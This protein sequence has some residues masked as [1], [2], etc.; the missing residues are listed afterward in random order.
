[1]C[2]RDSCDIYLDINHANE[3]LSAVRRAFLNNQVILAFS[4]TAHNLDYVAPEHIYKPEDVSD[5]IEVIRSIP[6]NS[7][8]IKAMLKRQKTAALAE[9]MN[10]FIKI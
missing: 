10:S 9:N 2:I 7:E 8:L 5:L 6:G 3:I 4:T 1:M